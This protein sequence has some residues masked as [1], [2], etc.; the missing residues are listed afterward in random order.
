M[1]YAHIYIARQTCKR[2]AKTH[3]PNIMLGP[4][5]HWHQMSLPSYFSNHPLCCFLYHG[6]KRAHLWSSL[7]AQWVKDL[8]LPLQW[9]W[10]LL[11]CGFIPWP[12]NLHVPQAWP[13]ETPPKNK[14]SVLMSISSFITIVLIR[15]K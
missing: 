12:G 1:L 15:K 6:S 3:L 10:S 2:S 14:N 8:V 11:C 5:L 13:K 7:V 4:H 9:L